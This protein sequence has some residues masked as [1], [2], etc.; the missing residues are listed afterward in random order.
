[1]IDSTPRVDVVITHYRSPED[2]RTNLRSLRD[3]RSDRVGAV[4]VADSAA[5]GEAREVVDAE[6]P[7]ALYLP[8]A[9]NVGYAAL[10]NAGI[11]STHAPYLLVLNADTSLTPGAVERL[12]DA[13]EADHDIGIVGPQVLNFDGTLQ[14]TAF[15][16]YRPLTFI[17]RRTGFG[18]TPLGRRE[19][20][21]FTNAPEVRTAIREGASLEVDWVMGCAFVVRRSALASV[22]ILD[23]RFFMYFEDVDLCLRMWRAGWSVRYEPT[24]TARH[25]WG[26]AS[27][28][29]LLA[30]V[31][32]PMTRRHVSSALK[33]FNKHGLVLGTRRSA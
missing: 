26:R 30:L 31:R 3:L 15:S 18:G 25:T 4:V 33:F 11:L 8:F 2:L 13:L 23:T 17:A 12:V 9:E 7:E 29:G 6:Y 27:R 1:M 14:Q 28:G 19:L 21:R 10:V 32:N 24:A 22:G 16:F 20:R 5:S